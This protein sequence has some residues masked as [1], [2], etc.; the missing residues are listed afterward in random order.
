MILTKITISQSSNVNVLNN[1]LCILTSLAL[2][3]IVALSLQSPLY[4]AAGSF[5]FENQL[6]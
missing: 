3:V 5:G 1:E 4:A 6:V 2:F